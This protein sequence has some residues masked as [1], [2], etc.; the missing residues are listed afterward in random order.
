MVALQLVSGECRRVSV[1]PSAANLGHTQLTPLG[2]S[3][4]PVELEIGPAVEMSFLVKMVLD[5]GVDGNELLQ[6]SHLSEAEHGP[7]PPSNWQVRILSP[8]IQP[9]ANFL[10][11]SVANDLHRSPVRAKFVGY[12]NLRRAKAFH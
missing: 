4:G 2:K 7:F 1:F 9:A 3:G 12:D 11:V 5:G 8:V 6:T 10:S